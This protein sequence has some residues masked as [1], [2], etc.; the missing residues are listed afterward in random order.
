MLSARL[1]RLIEDHAE[2]LFR[3]LLDDLQSNPRT[4]AYHR[5]DR[6]E[7]R[8]RLYDVYQNLG[9]WLADTTEQ[10]VETAYSELGR[11]R[12]AEGI[13]LS[14]VVF[15]IILAKCHLWEYIR[16][17]GL[18]DSAVALYQEQELHRMVGRFFDRAIY[19][20]VRGYEHAVKARQEVAA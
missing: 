17:C 9:R 6:E 2:E 11:R 18:M 15:A 4:P 13:P 12:H 14:E 16:T 19:H 7:L 20:T 1:V 10:H 3:G 5:L 8:S